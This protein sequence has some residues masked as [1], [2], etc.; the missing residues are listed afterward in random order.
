MGTI[1]IRLDG[2]EL[3]PKKELVDPTH[4]LGHIYPLLPG[5][6]LT[7]ADDG[8]YMKHAPG[9][10]VFGFTLASEDLEPYSDYKERRNA[11]V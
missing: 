9:L 6:V 7:R 1:D 11:T 4:P 5:D 8:T 3:T 2:S 10:G